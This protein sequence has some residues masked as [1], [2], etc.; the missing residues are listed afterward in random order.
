MPKNQIRVSSAEVVQLSEAVDIRGGWTS[1]AAPEGNLRL[2]RAT[3]I[4]SG[5]I[6]WSST[7]YCQTEP[8]DPSAYLLLDGDVL[9]ARTGAGSIGLSA[10]VEQPL[11]AVFGSYLI[12]LRPRSGWSGAYVAY[13]LKSPDGVAL[14]KSRA[15]GVSLPNLS[16]ARISSIGIPKKSL[17]DQV[18]IVSRI[19]SFELK[20]QGIKFRLSRALSG[21]NSLR[22]ESWE[23]QKEEFLHGPDGQTQPSW[24]KLGT[25]VRFLDADRVALNAAQRS[26]KQGPVPYYGASGVIDHVQGHTHAGGFLLVSEDGNNLISRKTPKRFLQMENCGQTITFMSSAFRITLGAII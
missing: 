25:L 22:I 18:S 24:Q 20:L 16:A 12:R 23:R 4:S 14:L 17:A 8:S 10:L 26:D 3:D 11:N 5:S 21:I 15:R 9:V 13:F 2:V 1:A 19:S 6:K 7:P